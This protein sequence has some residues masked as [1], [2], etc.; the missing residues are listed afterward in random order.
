MLP[1]DSKACHDAAA[2]TLKQSQVDDDFTV[3]PEEEKPM[4]YSDE[5]FKKVA[6]QWLIETDQILFC[7]LL[8][9][10]SYFFFLSQLIQA[11]EHPTFK[12][13]ISVASHVTKGV[14]IPNQKQTCDEIISSFKKQMKALKDHLNVSISLSLLT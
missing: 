11:F 7:S 3:I 5:V 8:E 2:E 9:N 14:K 1:E 4:P 10:H 12:H 13:M 6:I